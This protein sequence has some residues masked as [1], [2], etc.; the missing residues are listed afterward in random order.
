VPP[1]SISGILTIDDELIEAMKRW[2]YADRYGGPAEPTEQLLRSLTPAQKFALVEEF[3]RGWL[4]KRDPH[5]AF[6]SWTGW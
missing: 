5:V 6:P 3:E 1:E 2:K 4:L